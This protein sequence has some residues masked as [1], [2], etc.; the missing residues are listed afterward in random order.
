MTRRGF[1]HLVAA[2]ALYVIGGE[3]DA[4]DENH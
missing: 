4:D 1:L 2:V 3:L